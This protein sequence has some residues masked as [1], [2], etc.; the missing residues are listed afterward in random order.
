M[1]LTLIPDLA[2]RAVRSQ[3]G[4]FQSGQAP[5]PKQF[6]M[7]P[8]LDRPCR[9]HTFQC[10]CGVIVR[11]LSS[12]KESQGDASTPTTL[13][14][15]PTRV[16]ACRHPHDSRP[17]WC[18]HSSKAVAC[19]SLEQCSSIHATAMAPAGTVRVV[20]VGVCVLVAGGEGN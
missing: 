8:E 6:R 15:D 14:A 17:E 2:S 19:S 9:L 5:S 1:E 16:F 12:F 13:C 20:V 7:A 18:N 3:G 11:T 10:S 4:S